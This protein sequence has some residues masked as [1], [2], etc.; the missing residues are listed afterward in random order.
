M[1]GQHIEVLQ[2]NHHSLD[3]AKHSREAEA[4]EHDEEEDSPE[5]R[6]RHFDDGF[7]EHDEGQTCPLHALKEYTP[8]I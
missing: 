8:N 4:E 7:C 2:R 3:V 6:N 1:F 5:G